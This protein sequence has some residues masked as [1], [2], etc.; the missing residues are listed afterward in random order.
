MY[1]DIEYHN[2]MCCNYFKM[3]RLIKF[4]VTRIRSSL[5]NYTYWTATRYLY[6]DIPLEQFLW[7]MK[8]RMYLNELLFKNYLKKKKLKSYINSSNYKYIIMF[9]CHIDS[10]T[11]Y[12]FSVGWNRF[13]IPSHKSKSFK[14]QCIFARQTRVSVQTIER[15]KNILPIHILCCKCV[16]YIMGKT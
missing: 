5:I 13:K 11:I 2:I 9:I 4:L 16:Y 12:Y 7:N 14:I 6:I 15:F 8:L 3:W 10:I 1:T